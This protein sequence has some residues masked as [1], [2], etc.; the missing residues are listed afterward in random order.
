MQQPAAV[1]ICMQ[2][3]QLGQFACFVYNATACCCLAFMW[4][5]GQRCYWTLVLHAVQI[6]SCGVLL[7][8]ACREGCGRE[9]TVQA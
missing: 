9:P 3:S 8:V 4:R 1:H 5:D 2:L 6:Y 7:A